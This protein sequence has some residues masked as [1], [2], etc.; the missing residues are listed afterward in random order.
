MEHDLTDSELLRFYWQHTGAV[1]SFWIS[2]SDFLR[3]CPGLTGPADFGL[4]D[5]ELLI[6]YD[7][8]RQVLRFDLLDDGRPERQL[9]AIHDELRRWNITMFR[10]IPRSVRARLTESGNSGQG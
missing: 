4:Y 2:V 5:G 9:F 1:D 3:H 10:E 8:D 7:G 6:A